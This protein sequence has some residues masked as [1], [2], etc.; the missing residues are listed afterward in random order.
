[1][2]ML[3]YVSNLVSHFKMSP[4]TGIIFIFIVAIFGVPLKADTPKGAYTQELKP[5]NPYD[6][7]GDDIDKG[8]EV[9]KGIKPFQIW[10]FLRRILIFFSRLFFNHLSKDV[11]TA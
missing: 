7:K 9:S 6:I 4:T 1:M 10:Q 11:S 8:G 5:L 3:M 2:F